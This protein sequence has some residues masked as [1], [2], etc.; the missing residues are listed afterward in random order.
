MKEIVVFRLSDGSI[1]EDKQMAIKRQKEIDIKKK[2][3]IL[4]NEY[5][6]ELDYDELPDAIYNIRSLFLDALQ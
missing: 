2:L 4:C 5:L 3:S 6:K 1:I